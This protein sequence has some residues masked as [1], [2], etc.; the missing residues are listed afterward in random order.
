MVVT[1]SEFAKRV[2]D[3]GFMTPAELDHFLATLPTELNLDDG[4]QL[5]RELVQK[6][7]LTAYQA[8]AIYQGKGRLLVMGKYVILGKLGQGGMGIVFKAQHRTMRRTVALKVLSRTAKRVPG[9]VRRFQREVQAAGLLEHPNIV[10]AYDADEAEGQPFLVLQYVDGADLSA[11]VKQQGPL[12]VPMAV[13]CILQAAHG[14]EYAHLRGV[15]HRDIKPSNLLLGRDGTLKIL[16]LDWS[17][18]IS[19]T[20][21]Q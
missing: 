12:P 18:S 15:V 6:G 14:L 1:S 21:K 20:S 16:D 13:S 17:A 5:V 7:K 10:A 9:A 19:R 11:L 3:A 8:Q 2:A 4:G